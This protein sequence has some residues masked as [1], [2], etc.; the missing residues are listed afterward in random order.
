MVTQYIPMR[1]IT[2]VA[3]VLSISGCNRPGEPVVKHMFILPDGYKG[4]FKVIVDTKSGLVVTPV[5]R[6]VKITVPPSG[7]VALKSNQTLRKWHTYTA[8]YK[9]GARLPYGVGV[10]PNPETVAIFDLWTDEEG[11]HYY[12]VGTKSLYESL[13][14]HS[15]KADDY[16]P[17]NP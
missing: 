2:L 4:V 11:A 9:S 6:V 15:W 10:L 5:K 7:I 12:L 1:W 3:A 14:K 17:Q 13:L 16:L 8:I